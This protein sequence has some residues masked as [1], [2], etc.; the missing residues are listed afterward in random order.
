ALR[1]FDAVI[2][3]NRELH[4]L[5]SEIHEHVAL[6]PNGLDV[7]QWKPVDVPKTGRFVVGFAGSIVNDKERQIKGYDLVVEAARR[8]GV[9]LITTTK[10]KSQIP[11][12]QMRSAFYKRIDLLVHPVASGKEGCSNVITEAMALGVPVLTTTDCGFHADF[13]ASETGLFFTT[14][15]VTE[16]THRITQLRDDLD[17]RVRA[18]R[19][20]RQFVMKHQDLPNV[21]RAYDAVFLGVSQ[22]ERRSDLRQ[23]MMASRAMGKRVVQFVPFWLPAEDAATGR[24]RNLQPAEYLQRFGGA[25]HT[26][27]T[28]RLDSAVPDVVFLSQLATDDNLEWVLRHRDRVFVV[29]DICDDYLSD[30][31]TLAGVVGQNRADELLNL[32]DLVL[33]PSAQL[34][35]RINLRYPAV[36]VRVMGD[37]MDYDLG[38]QLDRAFAGDAPWENDLVLW[39]GNPGRGNFE[40][41]IPMFDAVL[42]DATNRLEMITKPSYIREHFPRYQPNVVP[43]EASEFVDRVRSAKATLVSH[44]DDFQYKSPNRMIT[45]LCSGTPAVVWNSASCTALAHEMGLP[46][47]C[48]DD[49]AELPALLN[50]LSDPD[51]RQRI[52]T[53]AVRHLGVTMAARSIGRRYGTMIEKYTYRKVPGQPRLPGCILLITHNLEAAEGAPRSLMEL[54]QGLREQFKHDVVVLSFV[55]GK[56]GHEYRVRGIRLVMSEQASGL[57]DISELYSGDRLSRAIAEINGIIDRY[58]VEFCVLNT[59]KTLP[60]AD[61]LRRMLPTLCLVRESSTEHVDLSVFPSTPRK[62]AQIYLESGQ[63]GFVAETTRALWGQAHKMRHARVIPNGIRTERFDAALRMTKERAKRQLGL[64]GDVPVLLCMGSTNRRKNQE[65]L[66]SA[67][68]AADEGTDGRA[69][70]FIVGAAHN[71]YTVNLRRTIDDLPDALRERIH[72]VPATNETGVYFRAADVHCF[73]SLN[74][75]Y[76][77]VIVEGLAFGLPQIAYNTFGVVEQ[78]QH[79]VDG[80]L[81]EIGDIDGFA[82]A[83][84]RFLTD[85]AHRARLTRN[86]QDSFAHLEDYNTM[87]L[88][89]EA[90]CR[91]ILQQFGQHVVGG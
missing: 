14:R 68:V 41:A 2:V 79:G 28:E 11:N 45:S 61:A 58:R 17:A 23:E 54:A 91:S 31:R 35:R 90:A 87:L 19:T 13:D 55:N 78:V 27:C 42:E 36:P 59:A 57:N 15:D 33:V 34:K 38:S 12:D 86:A 77:R 43:W 63:V 82:Q 29:Y 89:Y 30:T 70:L 18:R 3:L 74:E 9:E 1:P 21:A 66:V 8:A 20:G 46:E 7:A 48:I 47:L 24:L 51:E 62:A 49:P 53:T 39:F 22:S 81:I 75:S 56:L 65:D 83:I 60:L 4:H 72:L 10:G 16:I 84:R 69:Q 52:V 76:P 25:Y 88:A 32:A 40:S 64:D 37:G 50:R 6:I 5:F 85:P 73:T 44:A 26:L 67:F 80:E 71:E